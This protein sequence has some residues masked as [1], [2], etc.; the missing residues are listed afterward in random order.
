M[1]ET[2]QP[3]L[4]ERIAA[5]GLRVTRQRLRV[6]EELAREPHDLTAQDLYN[7]TVT[8]FDA[9]TR[10]FFDGAQWPD[11]PFQATT[12]LVSGPT[13]AKDTGGRARDAVGSFRSLQPAINMAPSSRLQAFRI[14]FIVRSSKRR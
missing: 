1:T 14:A 8:S 2:S 9:S 3:A 6:L 13:V 5:T 7:N 4:D 11:V 10:V 12:T